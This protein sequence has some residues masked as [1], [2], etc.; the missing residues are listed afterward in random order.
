[1]CRYMRLGARGAGRGLLVR[2]L[3]GEAAAGVQASATV[4]SARSPWEGILKAARSK[5]CDLVVMAS[6]GRR[7]LAG[8]LPGS[9]TAKVLTH[10]H[11]PVLVC[12]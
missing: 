11:I 9:E 6:H 4:S 5:H 8:L 2:R 7:G 10:S 1:M 12:R 3:A